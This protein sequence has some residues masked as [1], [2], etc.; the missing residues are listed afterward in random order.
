[1]CSAL[2]NMDMLM[3]VNTPSHSTKYCIDPHS[4]VILS[5]QEGCVWLVQTQVSFQICCFAR[6]SVNCV[7][8]QKN[9]LS[10]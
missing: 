3:S 8:S 10:E 1:M 7:L 4:L 9:L 2:P 6:V 5:L